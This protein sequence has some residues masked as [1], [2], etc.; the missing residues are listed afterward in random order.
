MYRHPVPEFYTA[1][2]GAQL[3][4]LELTSLQ[5]CSTTVEVTT[6]SESVSDVPNPCHQPAK[7]AEPQLVSTNLDR[8]PDKPNDNV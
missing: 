7:L 5:D 4:E 1:M 3:R 2:E 6:A 8:R